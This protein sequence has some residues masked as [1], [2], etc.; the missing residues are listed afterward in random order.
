MDLAFSLQ[1]TLYAIAGLD[2]SDPSYIYQVSTATGAGTLVATQSVTA[3]G[4]TG[5]NSHGS[6]MYNF[7]PEPGA[8]MLAVSGL[9]LLAGFRRLARR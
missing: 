3:I 2:G 7:V 1:M 9:G 5:L 8:W 6:D 4:S